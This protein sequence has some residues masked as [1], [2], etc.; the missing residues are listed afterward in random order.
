MRR[1]L[2]QRNHIREQHLFRYYKTVRGVLFI[3]GMIDAVMGEQPTLKGLSESRKC[4]KQGSFSL[5]TCIFRKNTGKKAIY[6]E[7]NASVWMC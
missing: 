6:M 1:H 5:K 7:I 2:A 3:F 4:T